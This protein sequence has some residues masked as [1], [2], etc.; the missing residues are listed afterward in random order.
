MLNILYIVLFSNQHLTLGFFSFIVAFSLLQYLYLFLSLRRFDW[1][2]LASCCFA[3]LSRDEVQL[4]PL[5]WQMTEMLVILS[6]SMRSLDALCHCTKL[7]M[8][9]IN[10][11]RMAIKPQFFKSMESKLQCCPD[12]LE[13]VACFHKR[14]FL[15][16]N[17]RLR[18][19]S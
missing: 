5:S 6:V 19:Y 15:S 12:S 10:A 18:N 16:N 7:H 9:S 17:L 2:E 11:R 1:R 13:F 8:K 14:H 4:I 3:H